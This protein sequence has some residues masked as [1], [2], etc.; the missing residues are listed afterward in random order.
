MKTT[1]PENVGISSER[2]KRINEITSG[3]IDRQDLSGAL[4]LVARR[5]EVVHFQCSGVNNVDT[6]EPLREDHIFRLF[7]MTKPITAVAA[8]I[9]YERGFFQLDTPV[10]KFI[11]EFKNLEV[12]VSGTIDDYKTEKPQREMNIRDLLTH[13][14][15]FTYDIV[16]NSIVDEMY[17]RDAVGVM[18]FDMT[19]AEFLQSVSRLPL[20]YFPETKWSYSIAS[21]IL[22]CVIEIITG[23]PLDEFVDI[24]I[25]QPLGMV[26]TGYYIKKED[27]P[28]RFSPLHTHHK[29][30]PKTH[31]EKY[32]D[33]KM[34]VVQNS[35]NAP[36]GVRF[37]HGGGGMMST[38]G[39]YL[40]FLQM[41]LNKGRY[42]DK[43]LLSP[44]TID[45]MTTNHLPGDTRSMAPYNLGTL[46]PVGYGY[47]FGVAVMIDPA[48]A[49]A[50]GTPGEYY[51]FG[52]GHTSFFV[53]PK[54]ELIG[55]MM[56]SVFPAGLHR[57]HLEFK[58]AVYQSIIE[59]NCS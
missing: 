53:D 30:M 8:M 50:I 54:E 56:A 31:T 55:I 3:Y 34:F 40:I 29:G 43:F 24:E 2:L 58:K 26:D 22:G 49:N 52:A 7:S 23:M 14:A 37:M 38:A 4:T 12:L 59:S 18:S 13:T 33:K 25:C 42:G 21:D 16:N 11:P 41:L 9:L 27:D 48:Q 51:W 36:T 10:S 17:R 28:G 45:L 46:S 47:G 19:S 35:F 20:L 57:V 6:G 5:G 32:P 39:D 15:G 1:K 44:K